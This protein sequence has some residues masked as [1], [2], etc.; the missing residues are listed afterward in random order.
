MERYITLSKSSRHI[1]VILWRCI[2]VSFWRRQQSSLLHKFSYWTVTLTRA[3]LAGVA[4]VAQLAVWGAEPQ[5]R[6]SILTGSGFRR[7]KPADSP[8]S[9]I[10]DHNFFRSFWHFSAWRRIFFLSKFFHS[11][12]YARIFACHNGMIMIFLCFVPLHVSIP[13]SGRFNIE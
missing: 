4:D 11:L 12:P 2:G 1:S 9:A 7:L 5:E 8:T 10:N 6:K 13:K 3:N